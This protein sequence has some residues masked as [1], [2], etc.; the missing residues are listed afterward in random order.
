MDF[1]RGGGNTNYYT[2]GSRKVGG[3]SRL[4]YDAGWDSAFDE[5]HQIKGRAKNPTAKRAPTRGKPR[6]SA[7]ERADRQARIDAKSRQEFTTY[8]KTS[9]GKLLAGFASLEAA[10]EY[11]QALSDKTKRPY[12]ITGSPK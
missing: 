4:E 3:K 7:A 9:A 5:K 12:A 1:N 11:A 10:K 2:P 6:A 8:V